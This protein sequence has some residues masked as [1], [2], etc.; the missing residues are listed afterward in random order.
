MSIL[1]FLGTSTNT[2]VPGQNAHLIRAMEP[3]CMPLITWVLGSSNDSGI[4]YLE[5]ALTLL[6]LFSYHGPEG[7]FSDAMWVSI[8]FK[9]YKKKIKKIKVEE[10]SVFWISPFKFYIIV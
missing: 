2:I 10:I 6:A 4:E 5:N 7:P 9:K 8:Y 1:I 3:Y